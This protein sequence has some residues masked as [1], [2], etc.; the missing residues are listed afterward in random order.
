V[1]PVGEAT[2]RMRPRL[3]LQTLGRGDGL[4]G[5]TPSG[6]FGPR[7]D[8][9]TVARI[10]WL[11]THPQ[12]HSWAR[13][14]PTSVLHARPERLAHFLTDSGQTLPFERDLL[15]EADALD[16][17]L[18]S[19]LR[20]LPDGVLQW[21]APQ[22]AQA[23]SPGGEPLWSLIQEEQ[24]ADF[25]SNH[26]P[27]LQ[28]LGWSVVVRPGFAHQSVPVTTWRLIV[29]P[30]NGEVIGKELA[31]PLPVQPVAL[32]ALSQPHGEGSWLITLG[33]EVDGQRLDLAPLIADLIKRDR[34]WLKANELA[35]ISPTERIL[36]RAPGG[37]RIETPA[38]PIKA[39]VAHMI[40][41][42]T[43]PARL[44]QPLVLSGWDVPRIEQLREHLAASQADRAGAHGQWQL[45]G[46]A[47]LRQLAHRLAA[48]GIPQAVSQPAGL[49]LTL[50]PYQLQGLA[51][52][53]YLRAQRLGGILADDMGLGKTAQALAHLLI[54]R[55]QGRLDVPALVVMPT[56]LLF[57]WQ[58]EAQRMAPGLRVHIWHGPQRQNH[59]HQLSQH[60]LIL[61]TYP[62]LW[63]DIDTLQAQPFHTIILDEAQTVKNAGSRA[64]GA[65]RRIQAR[66]RLCLTG[67]PLENHLG[68][69]W[70]QFDFL[71][72]G[73]LGDQR[74]FQ[75]HWRDPIEKNGE[76]LRAA[77][78][79]ARVRPFILRRRKADVATELPPKT[80]VI[81]LVHLEGRQK[82]LYESVRVAADEL[83]RRAITKQGFQGAQISIL[84]AL[85]KLRQ[86]CC[87]P[88]L[89]KG[90]RPGRTME[91][92]KL[93]WLRDTLP[94]LVDEGRRVLVFSQFTEMLQLLANLLTDMDC[95]HLQF[96]GETPPSARGEVVRAFQ[97]G[98]VPVLLL[99][100]KAGGVGLNLTAADTVIHLDP[101]WNPA[102]ARQATDRAHR[103]G[104]QQPVTVYQLVVAGSIEERILALQARKDALADSVLGHDPASAAKFSP[105]DLDQLLAP[106]D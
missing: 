89:L 24:F 43:D 104:Q 87:D 86:V 25:W 100:L 40:D 23:V 69:L 28:A 88:W 20:P 105:T 72:P 3:T 74:H 66:H 2:V 17:L 35:D 14:A 34:R 58:A 75:R 60:D 78:L 10:E 82:V 38:A 61:S 57:N 99:S 30:F 68:E 18:D 65:V 29:S 85:L 103:L 33:I 63:R 22:L 91:R 27:A 19:E 47:G 49:K 94:A 64:A 12:G 39:I 51:W 50:R 67:T 81:Q 73:F 62:L 102:V 21:R 92:A 42:M 77:L 41:L 7:A 48:V 96:T 56:S 79:A 36:L 13:P 106:L 6:P 53:Q 9:V 8:Q 46:E 52:L 1:S 16:T 59:A 37:K 95:P 71:M 93:D 70:S 31:A 11:Y 90:A 15:A 80:E 76:T 44:A 101:W 83:V 4:L 26:V 45:Q 98:E 97:A 54:E 32:S 55:E 5:M 84:D